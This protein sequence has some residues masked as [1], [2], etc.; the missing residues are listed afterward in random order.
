[1]QNK[2]NVL[3]LLVPFLLFA[4]CHGGSTVDPDVEV[5]DE[6]NTYVEFAEIDNLVMINAKAQAYIDAMKEQ[7]EQ[8]YQPYHLVGLDGIDDIEVGDMLNQSN[9][10]KNRPIV[11]S[12]DKGDMDYDRIDLVLCKDWK[13]NETDHYPTARTSVSIDN[14]FRATTYY[15]RLENEDGS[16]ISQTHKFT[17]GDYTRTINFDGDPNLGQTI[18]NVRDLGGYMTSFGVR[19]NQGLI[20]RGSEMNGAD[21]TVDGHRHRRNVDDVVIEK[22]DT[23]LQIGCELDLR[24]AS[25]SNNQ[26]VCPLG[27][28]IE[29]VRTPFNSYAGFVRDPDNGTPGTF[30]TAVSKIANA[31]EKHVYYHCWGGADRTGALSFFLN[32]MLG[33][34]LTDLYIDFELTTQHNSLRS[35]L[36]PNG[37]YDFPGTLVA[38]RNLDY[39]SEEMTLAELCK[40]FFIRNGI[41]EETVEHIRSFMIPGYYTG[42]EEIYA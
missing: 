39:Y 8:S 30:E 2:K 12:W 33:V 3:L 25:G 32:G 5:L 38:I 10:S 22:N 6:G 19:T 41:S 7:E 40:E 37:G 1:M 4:S 27:D 23:I 42:M 31:D 29:Y 9:N 13:F 15:Y 17:T 35:H 36:T 20:Y 26:T 18:Y 21:F 16:I 34:S 24:T 28:H 14:L 11:I